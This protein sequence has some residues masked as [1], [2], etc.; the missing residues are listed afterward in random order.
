[1]GSL[2]AGRISASKILWERAK[3][4]I[5]LPVSVAATNNFPTCWRS[6]QRNP[7]LPLLT[8]WDNCN[9]HDLP[10]EISRYFWPPLQ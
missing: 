8:R 5:D 2:V 7:A 4:E 9:L 3:V 10:Q 1:M 6:L